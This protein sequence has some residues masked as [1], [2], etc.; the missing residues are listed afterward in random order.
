MGLFIPW[1][2]VR[3]ESLTE[4]EI[5]DIMMKNNVNE[6]FSWYKLE[7]SNQEHLW[8]IC[9]VESEHEQIDHSVWE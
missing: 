4:Q 5:D 6:V 7:K 8:D 1:L 2:C 9:G 3:D